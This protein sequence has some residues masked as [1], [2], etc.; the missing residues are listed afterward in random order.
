MVASSQPDEIEEI[1]VVNG[2]FKDSVRDIDWVQNNIMQQN[3]LAACGLDK[4]LVILS[5]QNSSQEQG[6]RC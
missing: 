3:L 4:Q 6:K 2:L 1:C 5:V